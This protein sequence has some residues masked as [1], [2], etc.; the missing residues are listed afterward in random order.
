GRAGVSQSAGTEGAGANTVRAPIQAGTTRRPGGFHRPD[1]RRGN[2]VPRRANTIIARFNRRTDAGIMPGVL[3]SKMRAV[4]VPRPQGSFEI[5]EREIP[6]PQAG[7][8]RIKVQAC[9]VCHSD[10]VTKDG[11]FP[12][13][14]YPRVPGHEVVGLIDAVGPDVL[15]WKTGQSVGVGWNGGYCGYCDSCRRGNF[16]ACETETQVTGIT[17]D[18]GYADYMIAP[19]SAVALRPP[20]LSPVEAAPLMCARLTT[21]NAL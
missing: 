4:Q 14:Q 6:E 13:I 20:G 1:C 12:G 3:M 17:R 15:R 2:Q 16:F 18:G 7:M 5:V 8:V 9:G 19:A 10:T 11:L 21:F